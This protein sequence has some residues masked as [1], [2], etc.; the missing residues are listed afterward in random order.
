VTC[1]GSEFFCYAGSTYTI[2]ALNASDNCNIASVTYEVTGATTRSGSG[3]DASGTFAVGVSTV[4][5]TVDDGNGNSSTCS[6]TVT[7][8][9]PISAAIPDAYAVNPGGN[10]NTIYIGYGPSTLTLIAVGT[11]GSG[12]YTYLW[13]NGATT[14]STA[15]GAGTYS[16][17]VTDAAGCTATASKQIVTMD[18]RC[19]NKND[20]VT[21]CHI[22]P[23]NSGNPQTICIAPS[24]VA[25]HI[26]HGCYLGACTGASKTAPEPVALLSA[27]TKVFP[28]P[29][30]GVFDLRL[31]GY[32]PGKYQVNIVDNYGKLVMTKMINVTENLQNVSF[33]MKRAT[34][35][36]YNI[37]ITGEGEVRS[38]RIIIRN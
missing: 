21:V 11:G 3:N 34:P 10:A 5:W 35:G 20:K 33:D 18:I 14:Q 9:P 26:A 37:Q 1:S 7:V 23:G 32:K 38:S 13:S 8:N 15:T 22:P 28:N 4:T 6:V 29:A 31:S 12:G 16:V 24:A 25:T 30:N 19:G 2:P 27:V 36:V 17:T